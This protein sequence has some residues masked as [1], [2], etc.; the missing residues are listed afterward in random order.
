[1]RRIQAAVFGLVLAG[2]SHEAAAAHLGVD[3]SLMTHKAAGERP[4]S[5]DEVAQLVRFA[6]APGE[7][8][9]L[10]ASVLSEVGRDLGVVALPL[11]APRPVSAVEAMT[12][13]IGA[14]TGRVQAVV[15]DALADR[16]IDADEKAAILAAVADAQ[17]RLAELA[18]SVGVI[19]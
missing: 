13:G 17:A 2:V 16:R 10:A 19:R 8:P 15:A 12:L 18:A 3:R 7:V 14:A 4:A 6:A 1:M 11:P 9:T 5:L